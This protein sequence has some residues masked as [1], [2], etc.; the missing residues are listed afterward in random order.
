MATVEATSEI[1]EEDVDRPTETSANPNSVRVTLIRRLADIVVLPAGRISANERSLAADIILQVL[2]G[3]DMKLRADVAARV[4]HVPE[5]PPALLR[6]LLL[7]E[8]EVAEPILRGA[9]SLPEALLIETAREGRK[10][11]RDMVVRRHD[12]STSIAD[13]IVEKNEAYICKLILRLEDLTLSP[14]AVDILVSRSTADEE[15]QNLL[16]RRRELEP[17]HGFMMFWWVDADRRKRILTRFALDRSVIQDALND[18]YLRVFRPEEPP[19]PVVKEILILAER[20]HRPRGVNGEA[21][22]MD[23]VKRTLAIA[24]GNPAREIVDAVAMIAGVSV[25][26]AARILRDPGGE[27]YAIMCKSLGVPRKEFY[28]FLTNADI[29]GAEPEIVKQFNEER[30]EELLAIFDSMARDFARA[31]LRYWDWDGNPRIAHIT[32]LL[33]MDDNDL[34]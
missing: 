1:L 6:A 20:R 32:H 4:A 31:V 19:D 17:A 8:P 16:L 23:V 27:P 11:H 12:L 15:L 14:Y 18:L 30:Y 29:S 25:E 24:Y 13:V 9:E 10:K 3:V 2:G 21:V 33:G 34:E 28:E 26:L 22:S 7:D 5:C